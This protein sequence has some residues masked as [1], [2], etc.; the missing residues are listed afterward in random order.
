MHVQMHIGLRISQSAGVAE[1]GVCA[2]QRDL[3]SPEPACSGLAPLGVEVLQV[4]RYC[5]SEK[6]ATT[7]NFLPKLI[8][9]ASM[10]VRLRPSR[11]GGSLKSPR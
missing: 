9:L 8:V 10:S 5:H 1:R 3:W 11:L 2:S 6:P 4:D 7:L